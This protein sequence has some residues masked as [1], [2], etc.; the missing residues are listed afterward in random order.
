ML[1]QQSIHIKLSFSGLNRILNI[2]A[3]IDDKTKQ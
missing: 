1:I 2:P 3:E